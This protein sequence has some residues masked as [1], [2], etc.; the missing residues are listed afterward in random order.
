M[1]NANDLKN[2]DAQKK[3]INKEVKEILSYID[4]ELKKAYDIGKHKIVVNL[5]MIFS[6]PNMPN[7]DAQRIIYYEILTSLLDRN[8]LV[9]TN[10][11][12]DS[13]KY[14]ITWLSESEY[15]ELELQ[16]LLLAKHAKKEVANLKLK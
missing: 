2:N 1:L 4:E 6:I 15:N 10:L 11:S 12:A 16:N 7:K 9:Q 5:P 14:E 3:L 8:F 13:T